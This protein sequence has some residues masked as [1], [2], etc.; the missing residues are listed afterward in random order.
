M[1]DQPEHIEVRREPGRFAGWPANYGI[2]SWDDEIVVGFTLG[3]MGGPEGQFHLRD[4]DRPFTTMQAR[5][6][7]AGR[8]W[9]VQPFPG[10]TPGGRALSAD[11]HEIDELGLEYALKQ[12]DCVNRPAP[13]PGGIDFMAPD[14]AL[15]AAKTGLRK[16]V[17][18]FIYTSVDRC[19][20]WDGP[21]T[22]PMFG[23]TGVAARHRGAERSPRIRS[24]H[25]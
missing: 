5:S 8:T 18:S 24:G 15:M 11:E 13:C 6:S 22:L 21:Y 14:F 19:Q 17:S 9:D 1:N 20:S 7:D 10:R 4:M 3:Y 2:W 12:Q 16:G 25:E 23:L